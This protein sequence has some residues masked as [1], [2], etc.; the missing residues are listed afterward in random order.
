[1]GAP[2]WDASLRAV[3]LF[4]LSHFSVCLRPPLSLTVATQRRSVQRAPARPRLFC[5]HRRRSDSQPLA[6]TLMLLVHQLETFEKTKNRTAETIGGRNNGG[7]SMVREKGKCGNT[8][9][10][11]RMRESVEA[12][13]EGPG[14]IRQHQEPRMGF[15]YK[16]GMG[17]MSTRKRGHVTGP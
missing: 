1:M 14:G 13:G 3:S 5:Y 11:K 9:L 10:R 15:L 16:G 7:G 2:L 6:L 12:V 4:S 17:R 8:D